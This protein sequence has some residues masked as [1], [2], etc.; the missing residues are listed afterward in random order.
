MIVV[1][2]IVA[3]FFKL[4]YDNN[5]NKKFQ[6]LNTI[7][8]KLKKSDYSNMQTFQEEIVILEN[9]IEKKLL[10]NKITSNTHKIKL[11]KYE[12]IK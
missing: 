5:T 2:I 4:S 8:N 6:N 1:S 12:L 7:S 3:I 10:V 9:G 11:T